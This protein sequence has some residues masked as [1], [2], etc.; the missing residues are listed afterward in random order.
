MP[1]SLT[2]ELGPHTL[3]RLEKMMSTLAQAV[4]DLTAATASVA[5]ELTDLVAQLKAA[6][7][8][9]DPAAI[10]AATD[11]I[12]AQVKV[13]NDSVAAAKAATAPPEPPVP[14]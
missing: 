2:I 5:S 3:A 4:S 13:I 8:A 12:E 6:V 1:L 11:A 10:Q 9:N 14:A 7:S